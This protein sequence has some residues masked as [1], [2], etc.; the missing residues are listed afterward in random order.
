M[1]GV[2]HQTTFDTWNKIVRELNAL[3]ICTEK[4]DGGKPLFRIAGIT[5]NPDIARFERWLEVIEARGDIT[6]EEITAFLDTQRAA[7]LK[8]DYERC[9]VEGKGVT[10]LVASGVP[11]SAELEGEKLAEAMERE[12][13]GIKWAVRAPSRLG[14][15]WGKAQKVTVVSFEVHNY[16][17]AMRLIKEGIMIGGKNRCMELFQKPTTLSSSLRE[18]PVTMRQMK[19]YMYGQKQ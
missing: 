16:D 5:C 17:D 4:A 19:G 3:I 18:S 10:R 8:D 7:V 13:K 6:D 12:N 14:A 9:W 1:A 11:V 2:G 15:A